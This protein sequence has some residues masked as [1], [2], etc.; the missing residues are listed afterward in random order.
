MAKSKSANACE[1][2]PSVRKVIK[3]RDQYQCIM[4]GCNR[5]FLGIAHVFVSRAKGGLGVKENGVLLCQH[6]H[7]IYD[8]GRDSKMAEYIGNL[9]KS[10][11]IS[12]HGDII[13]SDLKY[14]K[15]KGFKHG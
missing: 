10:Y 12:K 1:F 6:H 11:I 13:I 5:G 3:E 14:K 4:P 15:W 7:T 8:N 9:C 2:S